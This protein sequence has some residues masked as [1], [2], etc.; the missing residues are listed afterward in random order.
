MTF[1]VVQGER[2]VS[3]LSRSDGDQPATESSGDDTFEM[4]HAHHAAATGAGKGEQFNGHCL[5]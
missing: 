2:P 1:Q 4:F 5:A 3:G